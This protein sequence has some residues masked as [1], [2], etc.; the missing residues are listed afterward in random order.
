MKP[1]SPK[2]VDPRTQEG[3]LLWPT[4]MD[5]EN[6][7]SQEIKLGSYGTAG[8]L[9]QR[10]TPR[11]GGI[12]KRENFRFYYKA[13]TP[14]DFDLR[15]ISIDA[16][17][18]DTAASSFVAIQL[19]GRRPPDSY[20]LDQRRERMSFTKTLAALKEMRQNNPQVNYIM[21]E[22]KANGPA[23]IDVVRKS[24]PGVVPETPRGSKLARAEAAAPL[25]E[26]HNVWVPNPEESPWVELFLGE[27]CAI[28]NNAFWDQVDTADQYLNKHGRAMRAG[29]GDS[30]VVG[31]EANSGMAVFS[32]GSPWAGS[33]ASPFER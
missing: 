26:S 24:I 9:Q 14:T 29:V 30:M 12:V 27:W 23:I 20:L 19:W 2:I 18:K 8:Q 1:F 25:I 33:G 15:V 13:D 28:P 17:F 6:V 21:I 22:D 4:R 7:R 3:E 32:S 31:G 10:P 11:G 5:E 16:A